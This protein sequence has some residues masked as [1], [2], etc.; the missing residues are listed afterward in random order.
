M[1]RAISLLL[2]GVGIIVT[3]PVFSA[4]IGAYNQ[5]MQAVIARDES[6]LKYLVSI[7]VNINATNMKGNT[8]LCTAIENQ[9]YQGYEL[10]LSQGATTRTPCIKAMK[11]EVLARFK[12]EQPPLGTYYKGA[13]L[14]SERSGG[15]TRQSNGIMA[16]IASLPY[17]HLGELLLGGI[18]V[19]TAFAVGVNGSSG[20]GGSSGGYPAP[21]DLN[22]N[23]FIDAEYKG[24]SWKDP[25]GA[26]ISNI[27]FV[28]SVNAAYAYA[29]GYTGYEV[30]RDSAGNLVPIKGQESSDPEKKY[31][32]ENKVKVAVMDVGQYYNT[33]LYN[34]EQTTT[35]VRGLN[36]VYG[37]YD[38]TYNNSSYWSYADG[39]ASLTLD[40]K[41][42]SSQVTMSQIEWDQYAGQFAPVCGA[43]SG[44]CLVPVTNVIDENGYLEIAYVTRTYSEEATI[45]SV[46][47]A[48]YYIYPEMWDLYQEKYEEI[49]SRYKYNPD[50]AFANYFENESRPTMTNNH[51]THVAGII[52]ALRNGV[53]MQGVA[54]NAEVI[55]V[56]LDLNMGQ[57][58]NHISD[59]ISNYSDLRII[60]LS[61]GLKEKDG[62]YDVSNYTSNIEGKNKD[63]FE[64]FKDYY[65]SAAQNNVALI[66]AAGNGYKN[67]E[68][69]VLPLPQSSILSAAP[70][71]Y[72]EYEN[73]VINVVALGADNTIASYSNRCGAT[74]R[75]CLAA[76]GGDGSDYIV[77]TGVS[78]TKE[79]WYTVGQGTSMAAP[80]VSGSLAVLLSAFPFLSTQDAVQILFKTADYIPV[81][82]QDQIDAYNDLAYDFDGTE[83][84]YQK[85]TVEGEYNAIYGRGLINL[86]A[87]TRPVGVPKITFDTTATSPNATPA[88]SSHAFIPTVMKAGLKVLPENL[89][90]LDDY[91][92]A[93]QVS[94]ARFV[95]SEKRNDSLRRSFRSFVAQD[96]EE[97]VAS[98]NLSFSFTTAPADKKNLKTGSM[99]MVM[100][101]NKNIQMRFGFT[102]DTASFGGS[103][104]GRSIQN[105]FMNMREAF[106]FDTNVKVAQNWS[107]SGGWYSGKNGFI[108]ED[109][110]DKMSGQPRMQLIEGGVSYQ[111]I[112]N[113]SFGIFGGVMEEQESLFGMRGAGAF[114]TDGARTRFIRVVANYQ[115]VNQLRI[116]AAYT[117]GMSDPNQTNSLI[118]V[119]RLTSDSFAFSTEYM[120]DDKQ[121]FGLKVVSP[122][123]IRSGKMSFDLP[124]ARD[125]YEDRV[126]RESYSTNLKPSAR[127]YDMSLFYANEISSKLSWAGETGVRLNPDHQKSESPDYRALFKLNWKW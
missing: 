86:E 4:P 64:G 63:Y 1:K 13:V 101:P 81:T 37:V 53:G 117:Y 121:R 56:K 113:M 108:D 91:S 24:G 25:E 14:T 127:E 90:V 10:L 77:S 88:S 123:K 61:I 8:A 74:A 75:F 47:K 103:Y 85:N 71:V 125:M 48:I 55:P 28:G 126:Y 112:K 50:D 82:N 12:A 18:A 43:F 58:L 111:G 45:D 39:K 95:K 67:K 17:P 9:D 94:T 3:H 92:R 122:L 41:K 30:S 79:S 60:N 46:P 89:V 83:E 16:T 7:G 115:P 40:G 20:G 54:Y 69:Y 84:A 33:D 120:L 100:R 99:S 32:T 15:L 31:I 51:G 21:L 102:Q 34:S 6:T 78:S 97:I 66:F 107:L 119:S 109:I 116:S 36:Y 104:M 49:G 65:T 114:D 52:A 62:S 38:E 87:A 27:N 57:S 35:S 72:P 118:N 76:P 124:V 93:Y 22:P 80:V 44:D 11:Q 70:L 73:L 106:G 105:P 96:E 5:V 23:D 110:L 29:R 98:D 59:V 68:G 42:T 2:L 19:G 26:T